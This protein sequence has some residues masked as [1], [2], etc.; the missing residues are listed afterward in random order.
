MVETMP[1]I[2]EDVRRTAQ[3]PEGLGLQSLA[4]LIVL[5]QQV[6]ATGSL[7]CQYPVPV[8]GTFLKERFL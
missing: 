4:D 5:P 1:G 6:S 7:Q 2:M 3:Q 8:I